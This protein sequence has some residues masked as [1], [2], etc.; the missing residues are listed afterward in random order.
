MEYNED[1]FK[2]SANRKAKLVW[3]ILNIIL[4]LNYA[5][6]TSEGYYTASYLAVFLAVGWIPFFIGLVTLRITGRA[7]SIYKEVVAIGYGLFYAFI[8][9]TSDSPIAVI[10]I[11]PL[12]SMM[13]LF[14]NRNYMIRCGIINILTVIF[15]GLYHYYYL[16]QNS[17]ADAKNYQLQVSCVLLCYICYILSIN[18]LN[19]S[20]G[21]LTDSIKDNLNRVITTIGQV[22]TASNSIVD[23]ITVVR[24]L[25][26]ENK[27]GANTVVQRMEELTRNNETLHQR[28]MSSMDMTTDIN[29]QVKNVAELIEQ[30]AELINESVEHSN[31]SS[32]ELADVVKT[33]TTMANLSSEV[34]NVLTEFKEQFNMVKEETSIID[35]ISSQTNLL[36]LNASIE[37]ARAGEAGRG[38]SVVADEIRNLSTGTQ[39]SS[40]RI[41]SALAHL[42]NTSEKMTESI[43]KTLELIQLTQG[44]VTQVNASVKN[45]TEDST[46]LGDNIHII[47]S[48]M[49]EVE[50]SNQNMV[51]NMQQICE[52]MEIMTESIDTSDNASKTMLSKYAESARNVDNIESIVGK[53]MEELG[54]GGF[55]GVQDIK[56]GM[57]AFVFT[58]DDAGNTID[59]YGG[60]VLRLEDNDILITLYNNNGQPL[61]IKARALECQLHI[62]VDNVMYHWND[63]RMSS[64]KE[65]PSGYY[66]MSM[67]TNPEV[68][69]RRKYPRMTISNSCSIRTKNS[70]QSYAGKMVNISANGF[71]FAVKDSTFADIKGANVTVSI[72]DF[73][74]QESRTLEGIVIRS[75]NNNGEY[76]VGCRMPEDN[77]KIQ[78]YINR[79]YSK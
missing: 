52:V 24:E 75:T 18:H 65:E 58:S 54:A 51:E 56:P 71:A 32:N 17:I 57:K 41:L 46:Q 13:V 60:E 37:A 3:M 35:E 66:K 73:E 4:T 50:S 55:M 14:K 74:L 11:L 63:A 44:K 61:D 47:D 19:W 2:E 70:D 45:I 38:F 12:T 22:K 6:N 36:A 31:I 78:D 29:T 10:Y 8:I 59:E 1:I 23:G 42:E 15:S 64:L 62:V 49:K 26:D 67:H 48:A 76:I 21:S 9:F 27:Q 40:G 28:T 34:E 77:L 53:L 20:D 5:S 43:T 68:M 79:K 33:T 72:P 30:M 69:N 39:N 7:S 16:G 25:S